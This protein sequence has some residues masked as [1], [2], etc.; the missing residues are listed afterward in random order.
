M[1]R[2]IVNSIKQLHQKAELVKVTDDIDGIITDLAD[3]LNTC[4]GYGLAAP[5][6]GIN[7]QLA[8]VRYENTNITLINPVYLSKIG[9][10]KYSNE[11]CLSFLNV[12]VDTA[13]WMQII[14]EYGLENSRTKLLSVGMEA[15]VIQH[16]IDHLIGL[17][18]FDKKW[19][20]I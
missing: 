9:K 3:T 10:Y 17:T 12:R 20:A 15:A 7:K 4:K 13:R 2:P 11:G 16:E 6:I 5:Q 19:K 1:I 18:I 8:I 14:I